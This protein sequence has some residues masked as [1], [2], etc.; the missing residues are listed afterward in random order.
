MGTPNALLIIFQVWQPALDA[1]EQYRKSPASSDDSRSR[2]EPVMQSVEDGIAD[3]YNVMVDSLGR[4]F[5]QGDGE[6]Q[7]CGI[8]L[9]SDEY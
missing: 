9:Q 7:F 8:K 2:L 3:K 4:P 5:A 6:N 1:W